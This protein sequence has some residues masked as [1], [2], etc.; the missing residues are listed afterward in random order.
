VEPNCVR[1]SARI[2]RRRLA[3]FDAERVA[4]AVRQKLPDRVATV[5]LQRA[6]RRA[7]REHFYRRRRGELRDHQERDEGG[8][9]SDHGCFDPGESKIGSSFMIVIA[10][11]RIG[12]R[13]QSEICLI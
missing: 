10:L 11:T 9:R 6:R 13:H 5:G 8:E 1:L 2:D 12:V 3:D 4:N 7:R